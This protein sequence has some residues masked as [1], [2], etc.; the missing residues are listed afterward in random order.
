[1]ITFIITILLLI[2]VVLIYNIY[3]IKQSAKQEKNEKKDVEELVYPKHI[4]F[5]MDGNGRWA[6]QLNKERTYGH[7]NGGNH[8]PEI[9]NLLCLFRTKLETVKGGNTQYFWYHLWEIEIV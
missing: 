1:M 9:F 7:L 2:I 4:A 8:L 6:N 5:I 3:S